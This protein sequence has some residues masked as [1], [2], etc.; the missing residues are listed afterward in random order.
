M[1][2][3]TFD[4][5]IKNADQQLGWYQFPKNIMTYFKKFG[6][7]LKNNVLRLRFFERFL[8]I[9]SAPLDI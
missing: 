7:G 6:N 5:Q 1:S 3:T 4:W 9:C 8:T 2:R